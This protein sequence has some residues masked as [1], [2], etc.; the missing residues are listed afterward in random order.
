VAA[1][2]EELGISPAEVREA[3]AAFTGIGGRSQVIDGDT[4]W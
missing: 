2:S 1:V 3:L 4:C